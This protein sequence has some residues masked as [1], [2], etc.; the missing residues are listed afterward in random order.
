MN[1][2]ELAKRLQ[3]EGFRSDLYSLDGELP[4]LLEGFILNKTGG[5]WIIEYYE[6]GM[7]RM[8]GEYPTEEDACDSFYQTLNDDPTMRR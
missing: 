8:L 5:R 3:N 7:R 6:R 4:S 1:R 2:Q